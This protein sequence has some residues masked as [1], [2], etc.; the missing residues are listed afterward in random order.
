MNTI[1]KD[2]NNNKSDIINNDTVDKKNIATELDT[3]T[4]IEKVDSEINNLKNKRKDDEEGETVQKPKSKKQKKSSSKKE[5]I[6]CA[7]YDNPRFYPHALGQEGRAAREKRNRCHG[8]IKICQCC[9]YPLCEIHYSETKPRVCSGLQCGFV[10][11]GCDHGEFDTDSNDNF[12]SRME[13]F[14]NELKSRISYLLHKHP[15]NWSAA[16]KSEF[17]IYF[18]DIKK[19][20]DSES[21][22]ESEGSDDENDNEEI[23]RNHLKFP[24]NRKDNWMLIFVQPI[25]SKPKFSQKTG[26]II[27][28]AGE[29]T[30]LSA[31][32][33][34]WSDIVDFMINCISGR[35]SLYSDNIDGGF[36]DDGRL[37]GSCIKSTFDGFWANSQENLRDKWSNE[38]KEY[39]HKIVSNWI[40][41][42]L[43][44]Y[45]IHSS[46]KQ[47]QQ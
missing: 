29:W 27:Q 25:H 7:K 12:R 28:P 19:G 14:H 41:N 8:K 18:P 35:E 22:E 11:E 9:A 2:N 46:D 34:R 21:S 6:K 20:D 23:F 45:K 32:I 38:N 24:L 47:Q 15:S 33:E 5:E 4:M 44:E 42:N 16:D 13:Y 3:T 36:N 39:G 31:L 37:C 26:K 17:K 30:D 40:K 1:D 43:V 10:F